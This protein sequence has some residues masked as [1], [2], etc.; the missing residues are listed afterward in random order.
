M[1]PLRPFPLGTLDGWG[2]VACQAHPHLQSEKESWNPCQCQCVFVTMG[3]IPMVRKMTK[4]TRYETG[5][6]RDQEHYHL[7]ELTWHQMSSL[8]FREGFPSLCRLISSS[9]ARDV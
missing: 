5:Q 1:V 8:P 6:P 2:K 3:M 4:A 9:S 7:Q